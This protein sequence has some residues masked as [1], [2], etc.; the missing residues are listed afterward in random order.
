[1][2]GHFIEGTRT[3]VS[4]F[5]FVFEFQTLKSIGETSTVRLLVF[6]LLHKMTHNPSTPKDRIVLK[7][8]YIK[9]T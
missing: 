1:M 2:T 8:K 5:S 7:I 4:Y 6:Q 9:Y 3:N